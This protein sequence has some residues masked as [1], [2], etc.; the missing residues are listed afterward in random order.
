MSRTSIHRI[1]AVMTVLLALAYLALAQ[2]AQAKGSPNRVVISGP[3]LP[4]TLDLT[5][6]TLVGQLGFMQLELA[7]E[8]GPID[9]PVDP[10]EGYLI[11][12]YY[13]DSLMDGIQY[14]LYDQVHYYPAAL[15][16]QGAAYYD[17][18]VDGT[19]EYDFEWYSVSDESHAL[20]RQLLSEAG[21][22][23]EM[24]APQ[25]TQIEI[26]EGWLSRLGF[27]SLYIPLSMDG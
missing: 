24:T 14:E 1:F 10:G 27:R 2:I 7:Y 12:R 6:E 22:E 9:P 13:D 11:E 15:D 3:G 20:M 25:T 18:I 19:S 17:G 23:L 26:I 4:T 21:V 5:D 16:G 8:P